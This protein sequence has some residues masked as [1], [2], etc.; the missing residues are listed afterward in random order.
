MPNPESYLNFDLDLNDP[1][2]VRVLD[3]LPL[4]SAP[5]GLKLLEH[6]KLAHNMSVLDLGCGTGFPL[7]EVAGRIGS[8]SQVFG[9]DPWRAGL[10]Q[11]RIKSELMR[12]DQTRVVQGIGESMPFRNN[13]FDLIVSN[14]GLNNATGFEHSLFECRRIAKL[15]AQLLF[16]MNTEG[17]MREFYDVFTQVLV[18]NG[19]P[20]GQESVEAHIRH[21]RK[22]V[23]E[24]LTSIRL[25]Q[26]KLIHRVEDKFEYRF[27]D[28]TAMFNYFFIKLAF[29]EP[30]KQLVPLEIQ[31]VIFAETEAR[32]NE[33][34][35]RN[36]GLTLTVPYVLFDCKAV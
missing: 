13:A 20:N 23:E 16:T 1:D 27:I 22:S 34:A 14:N 5:F 4:W 11:I 32:L 12:I 36:R 24:I 30:W 10:Y 17:T 26:F 2:K 8:S 21:K 33:M 29:L 31:N 19:I 7:L 18:S 3:E 35:L 15:G 6:V 28:A 25:S 9:L